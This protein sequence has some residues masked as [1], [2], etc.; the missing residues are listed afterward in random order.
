MAALPVSVAGANLNATYGAWFLA[1]FFETLLYGV[2]M[3]QTWLYFQW[4]DDEWDVR[5]AVAVV[6]F[7][8][9]VQLV[10]FCASSFNRFVLRFGD[11]QADLL[12]ED[13]LQLLANVSKSP[14]CRPRYSIYA[15]SICLR[16]PCSCKSTHPFMHMPW[17]LTGIRAAPTRYFATRIRYLTQSG[18]NGVFSFRWG[19]Y[20]IIAMAFTQMGTRLSTVNARRAY[21]PAAAGTV[22]TGWTYIVRNFADLEQTKAATTVQTAASL[23]CDISITTYLCLFLKRHRNGMPRTHRLLKAVMINAVNRG[24]LTSL[25]SAGTM[26]LFLAFPDTFWFFLTLAPNSKLYMISMLSTLNMRGQL[27]KLFFG[28]DGETQ[29]LHD[30]RMSPS[31]RPVAISVSDVQFVHPPPG[32]ADSTATDTTTSTGKIEIASIAY[33]SSDTLSY[34]A[35]RAV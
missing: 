31:G 14:L 17:T 30:V 32:V 11:L 26:I 7:L 29:N 27:T 10:F 33:P 2:G 25:T 6:F 23:V 5:C 16:S 1:L 4:W 12:W 13:S 20:F 35:G 9:T 19:F 28:R 8:E 15:L 21:R 3:I 34:A 18:P 24:M 22:Q